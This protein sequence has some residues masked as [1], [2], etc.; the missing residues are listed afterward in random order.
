MP[1]W[2]K[3]S[4]KEENRKTILRILA[5]NPSTFTEIFEKSK[6]SRA[7]L[8]AHLKQL[9][10]E[11]AVVKVFDNTKNKVVY[12][13]TEDTLIEELVIDALVTQLGFE[14]TS[15]LL[16]ARLHGQRKLHLD[17]HFKVDKFIDN[18]ILKNFNVKSVPT[19]KL[20]EALKKK[21]GTTEWVI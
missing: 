2:Y 18:F 15:L 10:K 8:T 12:K 16:N 20:L 19:E 6:V 11:K 14:I 9:L 1:Q 21:F 3:K 13:I 4:Q 17:E 7:T 5:K